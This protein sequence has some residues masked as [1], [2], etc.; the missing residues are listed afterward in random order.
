MSA[1]LKTPRRNA[2]KRDVLHT[3]DSLGVA[4]A[5][6]CRFNK[7]QNSS[8]VLPFIPATRDGSLVIPDETSLDV[9]ED[10]A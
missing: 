1:I 5:P 7:E 4:D 2:K 9:L 3:A 10:E 6:P 8:T